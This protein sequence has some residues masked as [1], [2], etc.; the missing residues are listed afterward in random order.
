M[1]LPP[2]SKFRSFYNLLD[3]LPDHRDRRGMRHSQA[4]ILMGVV[5]ALFHGY[6]AVQAIHAFCLDNVGWLRKLTRYPGGSL[7]R[8][9]LPEF[10][11][12]VDLHALHLLAAKFFKSWWPDSDWIAGDGKVFR[13]STSDGQKVGAVFLVAHGSKLELL[14]KEQLSHKDHELPVM[15]QLLASSGLDSAK[16][17]FDALYLA[18]V[19][20]EQIQAREGCYLVQLKGNQEVLLAHC[21]ELSTQENPLV[22]RQYEYKAHGRHVQRTASLFPLRALALDARW[23]PCGL[24]YLLQ[25][26]TVSTAKGVLTHKMFYYVT[27]LN[28]KRS[29]RELLDELDTA[30]RQHWSVESNNWSRDT[31]MREDLVKVKSGPQALVMGA[32]RSVA[33]NALRLV[34]D[35]KQSLPIFTQR[36]VRNPKLCEERLRSIGFI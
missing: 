32:L 25:V 5:L 34:R 10:L 26:R 36:L 2:Q 19:L 14:Q 31:L 4:F 1:S 23:G 27:N 22:Q 3:G 13:G 29:L 18:P 15:C 30:A 28:D 21:A 8:S 6:T 33:L 17:S 16:L 35:A 24:K 9:Y 7:S 12:T 11:A 20:L